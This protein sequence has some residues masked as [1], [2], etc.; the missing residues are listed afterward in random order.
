MLIFRL[1]LLT[2]SSF[3]TWELENGSLD[4]CPSWINTE[5]RFDVNFPLINV[6]IQPSY[7]DEWGLSV[8]GMSFPAVERS[9]EHAEQAVAMKQANPEV[10]FHFVFVP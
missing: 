9:T 2:G 10:P 1:C 8:Y 4:F 5:V 7:I 3:N 6:A